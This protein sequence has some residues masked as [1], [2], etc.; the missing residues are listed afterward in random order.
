MQHYEELESESG[1]EE[2]CYAEG[3]AI[4]DLQ[5][6]DSLAIAANRIGEGAV[7]KVLSK[8]VRP[9]LDGIRSLQSA[10]RRPV[11]SNSRLGCAAPTTLVR[12]VGYP[13]SGMCY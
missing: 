12:P 9:T 10:R 1:Q 6:G 11:Q 8:L 2:D 3:G 5:C 13:Y 7:S 4:C